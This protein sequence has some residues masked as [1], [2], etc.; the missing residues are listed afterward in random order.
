[1]KTFT[2]LYIEDDQE[3]GAWSRDFLSGHGYEV[4]WKTSGYDVE[5]ALERCDLVI[6]DIML[7][8]L[9]GFTVGQRIKRQRPELPIMMLTARTAI[10]D[11]LTGLSF[12]DD[13]MTKPYHPDEL[14]ARIQ[15]LLRRTG[16]SEPELLQIRHLTIDRNRNR[17][18]H[19]ESKDEIVLTG[20]Q[21][22]IFMYFL[23]H[24]NHILTQKQI[25]EAIW[26]EPH[27]AGDKT[28]TVHIRHL[29]EKIEQDP[30]SPQI[31]ETIRGVGYR[32][33]A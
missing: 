27:L 23:D 13:Y 16:V 32:V 14:L 24:L 33:R 2:I 7:P 1:M 17:I 6:V 15:V 9:D 30:A 8:G 21:F 11:K 12:A 31:I 5:E 29:R 10:E 28:L 26:G 4:I 22:H 3:I 19:T 25:Y 18:W 20:K